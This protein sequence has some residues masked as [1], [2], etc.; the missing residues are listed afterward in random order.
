MAQRPARRPEPHLR[1][2]RAWVREQFGPPESEHGRRTVPIPHELVVA[3][4][5]QRKRQDPREALLF[6]STA[7]AVQ[8][9]ENLRRT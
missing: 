3:L 9:T 4:R 5:A 6:P 7:G 2:R 8:R 1:V